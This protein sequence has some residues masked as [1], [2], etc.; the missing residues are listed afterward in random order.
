MTTL[1]YSM[2]DDESDER[3]LH[4]NTE[5]PGQGW[6]EEVSAVFDDIRDLVNHVSVSESLPCDENGVYFNL[7]SKEGNH[8]TIELSTAGFRICSHS[9]DDN[10]NNLKTTHYETI[11]AL[12]DTI[13]PLYRECFSSSLAA[14]L[15]ALQPSD[16]ERDYADDS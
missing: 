2:T 11:Y 8:F 1:A 7:E 10:D 12:L 13:S 3:F 9:F 16:Q 6:R 4:G 14:K 5:D 15:S